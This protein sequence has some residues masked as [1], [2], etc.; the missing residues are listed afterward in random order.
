M[1]KK[2]KGKRKGPY[3]AADRKMEYAEE[4]NS[5]VYGVVEKMLGDRYFNVR[6]TDNKER[7]S[8]ARKKRV[9]ISIGDVV[10][11]SLRD[12]NDKNA[13]IIYK[14]NDKEIRLLRKQ[15]YIPDVNEYN[16]KD[17]DNFG[18]IFVDD[19]DKEIDVENI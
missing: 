9:R 10:I 4:N 3:Q 16:N 15:G 5:Q 1:P 17:D 11:V 13:D 6:C 7:R 14:Y 19:G 12:F 2:K 8:R 18:V